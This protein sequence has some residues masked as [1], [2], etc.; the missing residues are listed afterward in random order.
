RFAEPDPEQVVA[1]ARLAGVHE[2]ILRLPEGYDTRLGEGGA[3]L[4]GGQRQRIGLA[5]AL[6]R[7]PALVVLDEPNAN[8]DEDGER[9]LLD[10][11]ARL[12]EAGRTRV[13]IT[14][15]PSLLA[16]VDHLLV[17]KGG[18]MQAFGPAARV[19]QA[20]QREPAAA[21][22]AVAPAPAPAPRRSASAY[23]LNYRL[24]ATRS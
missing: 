4:S 18:Q 8:L 22:P 23:S 16:S 19:L 2:L 7:L 12:G 5:R 17:L 11:L 21:A 14:H 20:L 13:L 15:K 10:A 6:Y 9:A 3:G 24:D 1:A